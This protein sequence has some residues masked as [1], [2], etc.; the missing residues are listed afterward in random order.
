MNKS[1][2]DDCTHYKMCWK[3]KQCNE[4]AECK[5]VIVKCEDFDEEERKEA[6][7]LEE[8]VYPAGYGNLKEGEE[9]FD[10]EP[11]TWIW[12]PNRRMCPAHLASGTVFKTKE[13]AEAALPQRQA[14]S[15]LVRAIAEA[16]HEYKWKVDWTDKNQGK[17]HF[18]VDHI[19]QRVFQSETFR[20]QQ[21]QEKEYACSRGSHKVWMQ[22]GD[23]KIALAYGVELKDD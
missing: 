14:Y 23:K 3:R 12:K 10:L 21:K 16:N 2:C 7:E 20:Q 8:G 15:D 17:H 5:C 9:Y 18:A 4:A 13:E 11:Y 1:K 6:D 19:N 22:L